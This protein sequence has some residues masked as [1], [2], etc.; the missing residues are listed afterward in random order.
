MSDSLDIK[1]FIGVLAEDK[2][3]NQKYVKV[4]INLLLPFFKGKLKDYTSTETVNIT[5]DNSDVNEKISIKTSNIITADYFGLF[6]NRTIPPD[7][8]KGE[9]VIVFQLEDSD[10]YYWIPISRDDNLRRLETLRLHACDSQDPVK[11]LEEDNMYY[12]ELDTLR[13]KSITLRTAK[14]DGEEFRYIFKIDAKEN[15]IT[16]EDDNG[17]TIKTDSNDPKITII[18]HN[19]AFVILDKD[20]IFIQNHDLSFVTLIKNIITAKN[21]D[22]SFIE[23]NGPNITAFNT[24]GSNIQL[25]G[26]NITALNPAG[27]TIQLIG[28]DIIVQAPGDI[29]ASGTDITINASGTAT[30]NGSTIA[31]ST[32]PNI[33]PGR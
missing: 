14:S 26:P 15:T 17:N 7:M 1:V 5:N 20:D 16:I 27:S 28:P 32:L 10:M 29:V 12:F 9:Q 2:L 31:L 18:N 21:K 23:I 22:G 11:E 8:R 4:F 24:V 6:S 13:G 25:I 19:Q 33:C 3:Y 30:I